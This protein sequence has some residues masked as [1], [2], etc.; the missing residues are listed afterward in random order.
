MLAVSVLRH[1]N[2]GVR[3]QIWL[4]WTCTTSLFSFTLNLPL[5]VLAWALFPLENTVYDKLRS[6]FGSVFRTVDP[7]R[8]RPLDSIRILL[9]ILFL[10]FFSIGERITD[11]NKEKRV[12]AFWK[13][14][15]NWARQRTGNLLDA[16]DQT[17]TRIRL[18]ANGK[19]RRLGWHHIFA[20]SLLAA[21]AL[22]LAWMCITQPLDP[23]YQAVFCSCTLSLAILLR[24]IRSRL[25]VIS[26]VLISALVSSRYLWWRYSET[27]NFD[28]PAGSI[29]SVLLVLAET[30]TYVLMALSYFQ[31]FWVLERKPVP[32]PD[33]Q[34]SWPHVDVC[35]PTYNESLEVVRATVYGALSLDWPSDKLHVWILDDGS[36][37]EFRDFAESA[38]AG[39]I[40][41][42]KH[43]HAK[44]GNINHALTKLSGE[45]VVIFD[46]DHIPVRSFLLKTMGWMLKDPKIALVQTPHHF[47]SQDPFE[48]NLGL[49]DAVPLENAL[50]HDF[51]QKGN[52]MWNACMFCGSCAVM[53]RR[54][55]DEIGGIAVETV[56]E[57]AHTSLKMLRRGWHTACIA[58]PL[59]AGLATETLSAHIGQRIRWAR[60]MTQIFRLD[61][62]L[63][64]KGLK[65]AQRLCFFS[66]MMYFLMGVPRL[67]FLIAPLPFVFFEINVIQAPGLAILAFVLPHLLHSVI[68]SDAV[69]RGHR[70]PLMGE[71]YDT[72][73][74][75]YIVLPTTVALFAPHYGKFNVTAKGGTVDSDYMDWQIARPYVV[76]LLLNIAGVV[77]LCIRATLADGINSALLLVNLLWLAYNIVILGTATA[78]AVETV[79]QRQHARIKLKVPMAIRDKNGQHT[80][81]MLND[82]SQ[83]GASVTLLP[84]VDNPFIKG[85]T[86]AVVLTDRGV[87]YDFEA[88]V[89]RSSGHALGLELRFSDS[90][91][92]RAFVAATFCRPDL[93]KGKTFRPAGGLFSGAG[94][95][96][97]FAGRGISGVCRY[98]P[99]PISLTFAAIDMTFGWI[100]S[101]IPRA[102]LKTSPHGHRH[103]VFAEKF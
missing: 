3:N 58:E 27:L 56:T 61:N 66:A 19:P 24:G 57:D 76:L 9:Q 6:S 84:L 87:A 8:I 94:S 4:L 17:A 103:D 47:Y 102:P 14:R 26:L 50:F 41:R 80:S 93:W 67:I 32:L 54:A 95:I 52:D 68:T 78:V 62:P 31:S 86:V 33:D 42:E 69:Q 43:D 34:T 91:N 37:D 81:A 11:R 20:L 44:A 29:F 64:G 12:S 53:R 40:R 89:R 38:G 75:C 73:L 22:S 59:A 79:Q 25:T 15:F 1:L 36:R 49:T 45:Y 35:I 7:D 96:L 97:R 82:F 88:V 13:T 63:L 48:R 10:I 71:I 65:L 2:R 85:D 28:T 39:Y 60:G 74:A 100:V 23:L 18:L 21:G 72:I 30:Y 90:Q 83:N 77:V 16:I 101:F 55:L 70:I 51:V 99:L 46:C 5:L 92:E 98:A